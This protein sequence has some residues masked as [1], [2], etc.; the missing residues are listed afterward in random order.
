MVSF[1]KYLFFK[2]K[3]AANRVFFNRLRCADEAE[4]AKESIVQQRFL[5]KMKKKVFVSWKNQKAAGNAKESL[6][7]RG[8]S[9]V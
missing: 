4:V 6:G 1:G 2:F 7:V 3:K 8:S 5:E 9:K